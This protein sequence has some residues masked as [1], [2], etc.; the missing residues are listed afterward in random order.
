MSVSLR[1]VWLAG[2]CALAV[3]LG[4]GSLDVS[5]AGWQF[6]PEADWRF[7]MKWDGQLVVNASLKQN[8]DSDE[9]ELQVGS[10]IR[11]PI[12]TFEAAEAKSAE[13][14][15]RQYLTGG[16]GYRFITSLRAEG[17][18]YREHRGIL[19]LTPR[20]Y[21]PYG[22]VVSDRNRV[23]L[24]WI[25]GQ[26]FSTRYRNRVTVEREFLL[27]GRAFSVYVSA[28]VFND[29]RFEGW[30]RRRL[31]VGVRLPLAGLL[32]RRHERAQ[33][34]GREVSVY[35]AY[36]DDRRDSDNTLNALGVV[37]SVNF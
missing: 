2:L 8:Q 18:D 32:R 14:K 16:V 21:L 26:D 4:A 29:S 33:R 12:S 31:D 23:D 9:Q 11:F 10:T 34:K 1:Q 19:E 3:L 15:G 36:Q 5:A 25:D 37:Y 13:E 28:E 20:F 6:W 30:D 27:Q 17:D 7:P 22:I 35:Y 24:R